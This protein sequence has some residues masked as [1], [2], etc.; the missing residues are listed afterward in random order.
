MSGKLAKIRREKYPTCPRAAGRPCRPSWFSP[1]RPLKGIPL[2]GHIWTKILTG[3]HQKLLRGSESDK[4]TFICP[5]LTWSS[6]GRTPAPCP[7]TAW[8]AMQ[9][10]ETNSFYSGFW[11]VESETRKRDSYPEGSLQ[12]W[13]D[14]I[15]QLSFK[16]WKKSPQGCIR[17]S[18][19]TGQAWRRWRRGHGLRDVGYCNLFLKCL[20][21]SCEFIY[22]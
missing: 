16:S 7:R 1:W 20:L 18:C 17:H 5:S 2:W 3:F 10:S 8:L 6:L 21:V 15:R 13:W 4:I 9:S 19:R 11:V 12:F 22:M 14:V